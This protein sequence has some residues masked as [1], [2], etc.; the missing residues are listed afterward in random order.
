MQPD[1][2]DNS[3]S[4]HGSCVTSKAAGAK[5]GVAKKARLVPVIMKH[6]SPYEVLSCMN[7]V[8]AH[9]LKPKRQGKAVV[10][11]AADKVYLVPFLH[12]SKGGS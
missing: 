3:P 7:I 5:Y 4:G 6:D 9:I 8:L 11:F 10:H 1:Y 2:E 12:A